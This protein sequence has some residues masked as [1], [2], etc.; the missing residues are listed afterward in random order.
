M[1][2]IKLKAYQPFNVLEA[3]ALP[4]GSEITLVAISDTENVRVLDTVNSPD[5]EWDACLPIVFGTQS[6]I[7]DSTGVGVWVWSD[8]N[9]EVYVDKPFDA[10]WLLNNQPT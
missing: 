4:A 9:A 7:T 3:L 6:V 10:A 2:R 8:D 1:A 5:V